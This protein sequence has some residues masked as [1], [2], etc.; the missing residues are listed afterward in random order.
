[1]SNKKKQNLSVANCYTMM[2]FDI[3]RGIAKNM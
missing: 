3:G 2:F 1:M